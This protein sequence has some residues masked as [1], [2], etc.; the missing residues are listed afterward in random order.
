MG[1]PVQEHKDKWFTDKY[2]VTPYNWLPEV[3]GQF[4]LPERVEIHDATIREG[5]QTPGVA[6]RK[7]EQVRIAE[8]LDELGV[9]RI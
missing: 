6:F 2:W 7:D 1:D 4:H 8:A 9:A 5:Q 3:R